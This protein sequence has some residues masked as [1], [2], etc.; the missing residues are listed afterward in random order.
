MNDS[1]KKLLNNKG[2]EISED[3]FN[4][5]N[6]CAD[7]YKGRTTDWHKRVNVNGVGCE[8]P[9][10]NLAKR[11]CAD[12]ANLCEI[13]EINAGEKAFD[14][15]NEIL[16][17]NR[18]ATMYRKQLEQMSAM[19]TVGCYLYVDNAQYTTDG[20]LVKGDVRLNYVEAD[21]IYPLTVVNEEVLEVAFVGSNVVKGNREDV[22]VI[23]TLEEGKYTAETHT[24]DKKGNEIA[25]KSGSIILGDVK[26][27]AIMRTAEVN[28]FDNMEGYGYPKLW[29]SIPVLRML[30]LAFYILYGDL[31]KGEKIVFINELLACINEVDG[32]PTLTPEQKKLFV[33]LGE[34]LPQT[35]NV[36][37]EYNPEL[38]IDEI[39]KIIETLLSILSMTF[40]FGTKKYTFENGQIKTASEYIG[41]RQ[42]AM[43]ELNKQRDEA[44]NYITDIINAIV[45]FESTF[46]NVNYTVNEINVD[47]DD[48]YVT[49]KETEL[50]RVRT[51]ALQFGIPKLTIWYLM[52]AY[53]LDEAEAT[54]LVEG[55]AEEEEKEA[56]ADNEGEEE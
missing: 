41:E 45:W 15:I 10:V 47:F 54:A 49:D 39:T 5:I 28:N 8:I 48:S 6:A 43:Q 30:D 19:G 36:I 24:F 2:Y 40:G 26:P 53:N 42:D 12:D 34:K 9:T 17:S 4:V 44:V 16:K 52:S 23:F 31:D 33:L 50:E 55:K 13:V 14:G 32:K 7:W 3:A 37:Q 25:D 56:T 27:F 18:F 21:G 1:I 22:C 38:R 46:N 51:D 20:K 35:P 29:T 11:V